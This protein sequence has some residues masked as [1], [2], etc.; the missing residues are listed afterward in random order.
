LQVESVDAYGNTIF[1]NCSIFTDDELAW[2]L[3]CSLEE[4]NAMPHF[5]QFSFAD[6]V[7][8]ERYG[9]VIVEGAWIIALAAQMLIESGREMSINDNG[10]AYTP[11]TL[12]ATIN[13]ELSHFIGPHRENLKF[14]K[15]CI[16]PRPIGF[17][18]YR[19]LASNPSLQKLRHLRDRRIV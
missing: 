8:Y 19:V 2:F 6:Q 17:G 9:Y 5:T 4:F 16:K 3:R 15:A 14:I 13:N 1:T 7:I 12:S 10:V 18:G 11:P